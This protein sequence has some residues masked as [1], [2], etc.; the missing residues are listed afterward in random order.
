MGRA[1]SNSHKITLLVLVPFVI[2]ILAFEILPLLGMLIAS[3]QND[4]GQ[5]FTLGQ[6]TKALSN[7]FYTQAIKNSIMISFYSS[8]V[9]TIIA[10]LCAYS[11][12]RFTSKIRDQLLMVSNMISNFAGVPLAFAYIILLGNNG[13]FTL[14]FQKLGWDVLGSFD[15]YS[16]TGLTVIYI[17]FQIPL[18]ILLLYPSYYGVKEEWREA[19]ALL[20]A[21]NRKFWRYIGIPVI[22]PGV[23]GT[24]SILFANALGAY[25]TAYALTTS[26]LNLLPIR[27]GSLVSGDVYPRPELGSA[28]AIML[29]VT[30]L[31]ALF[32]NERMLRWSRRMK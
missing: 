14:L 8:V 24:F 11:I 7:P 32:I 20:G 28:L 2:W 18:A 26:N 16:W 10:M 4:E 1:G 22:L 12:T 9:G 13:M 6:Y 31:A 27:I 5:G 3:F 29:A 19:S 21:S 23:V 17:Y 30:M 25:A 15:L